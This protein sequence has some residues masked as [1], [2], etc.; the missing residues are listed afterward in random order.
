MDTLPDPSP[1]EPPVPPVEGDGGDG[2]LVH[3]LYDPEALP[4]QV[5]ASRRAADAAR[6]VV[7]GLAATRVDATTLDEVTAALEHLAGVLEPHRPPSRYSQTGGLHG[8]VHADSHVWESHPF[9][10]PSHPLAPP[11]VVRR[12]GDRAVGHATFGH[13]Y[14]GPPGAVHGGIVAA[15]FDMVLGAATSVAK[16]SGLTGTLTVRYRRP[17][18]IDR[19]IRY[20]AWV[21]QAEER[22]VHVAGVS[23]CDGEV[24]AEGS[25]IF[26][27]VDTRRYDAPDAREQEQGT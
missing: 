18:P 21:E 10:G 2:E 3:N 16:L 25:A 8:G 22:K 17:T 24:L 9:I 11:F 26:V 6:Q 15:M 20:E 12:V 13:V 23:T 5:A 27:R 4:E 1:P 19:E 7:A 14:E